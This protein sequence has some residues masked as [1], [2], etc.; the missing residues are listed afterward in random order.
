M[1]LWRLS[2]LHLSAISSAPA[3]PFWLDPGRQQVGRRQ[4][5]DF[6]WQ[7]EGTG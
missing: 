6:L 5:K 7:R 3:E 2:S 4:G 1:A